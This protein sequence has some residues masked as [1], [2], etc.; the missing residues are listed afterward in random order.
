[1]VIADP[2]QIHQIVMNLCTNAYHAMRDTGGTL[3]VGL[4][5]ID[6]KEEDVIL[7]Q[8]FSPGT[9]LRLEIADTGIGIDEETRQKIFEPYFTTKEVGEGTGLGLAVVHGI[10]QSHGGSISVYSEM[11]TGTTF[12]VYLP[13]STKGMEDSQQGKERAPVAQGSERIMFVDD[14]EKLVAI[15]QEV[16]PKYGYSLDAFSNGVEALQEFE[17]NPNRYD[18]LITDMA[19][20]Y[21]N[22]IEL[23]SR[24]RELRPGLPV[25]LC[26]GFSE[27][28]NKQK[29][30]AL[31][32]EYMPK[33]V[34]MSDLVRLVRR[35]FDRP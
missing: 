14:E 34:I 31:E 9:Y 30:E 15:A 4:H 20:P 35:V 18:M 12:Q 2:T 8:D 1:M 17:K 28:L 16:L 23:I 21:M 27:F 32:I 13:V 29:A 19:M 11:G 25:I 24:T 22:G 33:P 7:G 5:E 6:I 3:S 26:S 10:V